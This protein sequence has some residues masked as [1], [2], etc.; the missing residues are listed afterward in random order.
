MQYQKTHSTFKT[1]KKMINLSVNPKSERLTANGCRQEKK[2]KKSVLTNENWKMQLFFISFAPL[3][4]FLI[5]LLIIFK[6]IIWRLTTST[7]LIFLYFSTGFSSSDFISVF[8][9]SY[10]FL[11]RKLRI[12]VEN[13]IALRSE[14][15]KMNGCAC[16][17]WVFLLC[18]SNVLCCF[19]LLLLL[20]CYA[21]V[22]LFLLIIRPFHHFCTFVL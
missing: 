19:F 14:W 20:F 16:I 8:F 21:A 18:I 10:V 13:E 9:S 4:I 11:L 15:L 5:A 2:K 6:G 7:L 12:A 1:I 17:V 22:F 3:S